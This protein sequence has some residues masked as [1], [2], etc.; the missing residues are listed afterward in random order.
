MGHRDELRVVRRHHPVVERRRG[1]V[2]RGLVGECLLQAGD[3]VAQDR[4]EPLGALGRDHPAA[5]G[6]QQLIVEQVAEAAELVA[7][8]G[9][10]QAEALGGPG[11][12]AFDEQ[13]I[14]GDQEVGVDAG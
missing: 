10:A 2:E 3:G 11:H 4:G 7:Q 14:E 9:L 12:A 6:D 1:G 8:R 5:G 13:R